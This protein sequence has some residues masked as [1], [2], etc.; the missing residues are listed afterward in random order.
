VAVLLMSDPGAGKSSMVRGLAKS[1][2]IPCETVLGS[3][4]EPADFSGLP[5]PRDDDVVLWPPKWARN[6]C[7]AGAGILLLDELTTCPPGVQAAML[8]VALERMVGDVRLPR[9][10]VIVACANPPDKAADGW[11]LAPPLANRFCHV[12]FEPTTEEYIHGMTTGWV[13][14]PASRAIDAGPERRAAGRAAVAGFLRTRPDLVHSYPQT[15]AEA[16]GAWPSRRTWTM[17]AE[18]VARVRDD[19]ADARHAAVYGLVGEGPGTEFLNWLLAADLPDPAAV[20][21]DPAGVNWRDRPDRVWAILAGVVAHCTAGKG[22]AQ[23]WRDAWGPLVAAA[24]GGN[25]DVAAA[26]SREL[27]RSRPAGVLPPAAARAFGQF[28]EQAGLASPGGRG[29][30]QERDDLEL[31]P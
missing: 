16:S 10:V 19:D 29:V 14:P 30:R 4:R 31:E 11:E 9:E 8:G 22:S 2:E 21:A 6:L 20:L 13:S 12:R 25:P 26:V 7:E 17:T 18:V 23:R 3:I 5:V 15:A 1:R 24:A 28:L 27:A